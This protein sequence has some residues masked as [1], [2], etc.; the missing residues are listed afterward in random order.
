MIANIAPWNYPWF[1]SSNVYAPA[2]LTGVFTATLM[3]SP[4]DAQFELLIVERQ[5]GSLQ[6]FRACYAHGRVSAGTPSQ[7]SP[8]HR[9]SSGAQVFQLMRYHLSR[10][11]V[12]KEVMVPVYGAGDVGAELLKLPINGVFF[13][14][15]V[16]T[17][18]KVPC[19][20]NNRHIVIAC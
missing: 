14:G 1:V 15:S 4:L 17:G 3:L 20:L 11:G 16:A 9:T 6:A 2:L 18:R 13:T 19:T 7:V 10:A 8:L 12:P 5:C